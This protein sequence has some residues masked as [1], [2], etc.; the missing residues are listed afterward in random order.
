MI[1]SRRPTTAPS[2]EIID[3]PIWLAGHGCWELAVKF[4]VGYSSS[5]ASNIYASLPNSFEYDNKTWFKAGFR[6]TYGK[7][8]YRTE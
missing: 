5:R 2:L 1:T 6:I 4:P 3:N 8:W 7:A